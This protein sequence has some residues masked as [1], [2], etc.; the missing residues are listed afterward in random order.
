MANTMK[1]SYAVSATPKVELDKSEG[2]YQAMTVIHE[3]VRTSVGGGGEITS[4]D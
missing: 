4:D 2:L 3:D 1:I